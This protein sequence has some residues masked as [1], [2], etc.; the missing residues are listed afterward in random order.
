MTC[1]KIPGSLGNSHD[2]TVKDIPPATM[3][4]AEL[5]EYNSIMTDI[6]TYLDEFKAEIHPGHGDLWRISLNLWKISRR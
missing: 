5:Q 3:T 4:D 2:A 6:Q 1:R